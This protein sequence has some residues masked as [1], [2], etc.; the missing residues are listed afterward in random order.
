MNN[1]QNGKIDL[2]VG[3]GVYDSASVLRP[4]KKFD[5]T[6]LVIALIIL[7]MEAAAILSLAWQMRIAPFDSFHYLGN[8]RHIAGHDMAQYWAGYIPIR[9][10]L[11]P[12]ILAFFM[13]L[14]QPAMQGMAFS[15]PHLICAIISII[16]LG[17]I[18]LLLRRSFI[19]IGAVFGVL[20]IGLNPLFI[21]YAPVVMTDITGMV[22]LAT[23]FIFYLDGIRKDKT[24]CYVIAG[25]L[26]GLAILAKD[27]SILAIPAL[28][29]FEIARYVLESKGK[30][31]IASA[32]LAAK[33]KR[34]WIAV[35]VALFVWYAGHVVVQWL[36]SGFSTDSFVFVFKMYI[37]QFV[38]NSPGNP[39]ADPFYEY[40]LAI[41]K[42]FTLPLVFL[43]LMGIYISI[44]SGTTADLLHLAWIIVFLLIQ[45]FIMVHKEARYLFPI[46]P[47]LAYF[48]VRGAARLINTMVKNQK[49]VDSRQVAALMLV[50]AITALFLP[51]NEGAAMLSRMKDQVFS[52]NFL[53]GI[54]ED[55]DKR[56]PKTGRVFWINDLYSIYPFQ[57]YYLKYD[58]YFFFHH[59]GPEAME[60]I[61]GRRVQPLTVKAGDNVVDITPSILVQLFDRDGAVIQ[62]A[63][64]VYA[65][66][67]IKTI[68]EKP[69]TITTIFVK[70]RSLK[71][72][73]DDDGG[74]A[75]SAP[76]DDSINVS[77]SKTETGWA[78]NSDDLKGWAAYYK[79]G[80]KSE[81]KYLPEA[82]DE[83]P[84]GLEL[85]HI[86]GMKYSYR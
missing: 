45:T 82:I 4:S 8:A 16:S 27:T 75:Y 29:V 72:V 38:R 41:L 40:F 44:K 74:V 17:V 86:S 34:A 25:L 24:S 32:I 10:P 20:A 50:G 9:P 67:N 51:A 3:D 69:P 23:A 62:S 33:D 53:S 36:V 48:I 6:I 54:A 14:Y 80:Q 31:P 70:R 64:N 18:Y 61:T 5:R 68:P 42:T 28:A 55:I 37:N 76:N 49:T 60:Y 77:F 11:V 1:G 26:L 81:L 35:L 63:R 57:P 47:S 2:S 84:F 21:R 7:I 85:I 52:N 15:G 43:I 78:F 30:N 65:T 22:L 73:N 13:F 79:T 83:L 71:K 59:L 19:K 12:V 58:E 56:V 46:Y 66:H 39:G